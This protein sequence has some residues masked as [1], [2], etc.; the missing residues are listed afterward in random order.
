MLT[1]TTIETY[2]VGPKIGAGAFGEIYAV[3][4]AGDNKIFALKVEPLSNRRNILELEA[5]VLKRLSPCPYFPKFRIFG[6]TSTYS[7]LVM[8]LLGPSLSTVVKRLPSGRL[9]MSTGLRVANSILCG[10]ESM[11]K[12][13]FIHRDVKPSNILLRRSRE[14]PIAII[15]FGLSRVYVD[16][17]TERHLPARA[18]PGFRGTAVYASPNAHMHQDLSRRDDL[19]SWF[20]LVI[21][22]M[23]G[24]LPWKKLENRAEILHMK[25]R[26]SISNLSDQIAH[27]LTLI[28]DHIQSLGFTDAPNY[29]Y[30]HDLLREA[31]E[32]NNVHQSDE[33]DWHPQILQMDGHDEFN[34][35]QKKAYESSYTSEGTSK[36]AE[37]KSSTRRTRSRLDSRPLLPDKDEEC[38]DCRI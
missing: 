16:R 21:D 3:R 28:W 8:E 15:D 35:E 23:A 27:Q 19:I 24:P 7:W 13:G 36:G 31:C 33:W 30:M 5:S 11:H 1:G 29:A 32:Q 37:Y 38:C 9:S 6:R 22:V 34:A 2:T 25:R 4:N 10:L 12:K 20:Y 26:I 17:K 14:Y 18:H